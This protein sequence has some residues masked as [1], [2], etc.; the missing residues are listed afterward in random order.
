[1]LPAYHLAAQTRTKLLILERE[2][3]HTFAAPSPHLLSSVLQTGRGL[4]NI[5]LDKCLLDPLEGCY[6]SSWIDMDSSIRALQVR[7]QLQEATSPEIILAQAA[8][9][10]NP[11]GGVL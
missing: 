10:W 3:T 5:F 11:M 6:P 1:M 9:C 7:L 4:E 2:G 8:G